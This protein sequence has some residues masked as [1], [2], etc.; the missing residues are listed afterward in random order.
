MK[1][2]RI[3]IIF[4]HVLSTQIEGTMLDVHNYINDFRD[5]LIDLDLYTTSPL[6][7][8]KLKENDGK[9]TFR[10]LIS[11]N[12]PIEF[13]GESKLSY[14]TRLSYK[15]GLHIRHADIDQDLS[16]SYKLLEEVAEAN[17]LELVKPY[18]NIVINVFGDSIVD[19]YAPIKVVT[20]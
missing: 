3:P 8:Q 11:V 5:M 18:M 14:V 15:D 19:I 12:Q 20:E 10:L 4:D 7:Y 6:I 9:A 13:K 1:I 2:R 17:E 16:E